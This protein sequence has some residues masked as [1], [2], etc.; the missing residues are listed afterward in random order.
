MKNLEKFY[1]PSRDSEADYI[2]SYHHKIWME[3]Y[4][5]N[6]YPFNIFPDKELTS[7]SFSPITILCGSNGSGKSTLLNVIA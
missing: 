6:I 4:S 1:I 3:C 5:D 2:L 7:L